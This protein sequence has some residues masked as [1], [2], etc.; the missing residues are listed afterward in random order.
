MPS[1]KLYTESQGRPSQVKYI[2]EVATK[3]ES[4]DKKG[5]AILLNEGKWQPLVPN[6]AFFLVPNLE[7][8]QLIQHLKTHATDNALCVKEI[9]F[10]ILLLSSTAN[11]SLSV[12][13]LATTVSLRNAPY[14]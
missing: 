11:A 12:G 6:L 5:L 2:Q 10:D 3:N 1:A 13:T 4:S 14:R 7:F 8:N 9:N